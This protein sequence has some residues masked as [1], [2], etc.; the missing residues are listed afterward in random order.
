LTVA[1]DSQVVALE[2][3]AVRS[4]TVSP[5]DAGLPRSPIEAIHGGDAAHNATAL[6]DVLQGVPGAYRD[7]VLLNAAAALVVAGRAANLREGV[8]LAAGTIASGSA[9]AALEAL[10]R[11]TAPAEGAAP[12]GD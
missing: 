8:E 9:F 4:F 11:E 1:G 5:E 3:G 7:T 6:L 10:R 2:H 12:A